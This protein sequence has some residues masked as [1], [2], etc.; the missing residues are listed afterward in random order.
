MRRKAS[1]Q[2][3]KDSMEADQAVSWSLELEAD[4]L[5]AM[6]C[7]AHCQSHGIPDVSCMIGIQLCIKTIESFEALDAF[8]EENPCVSHPPASMRMVQLRKTYTKFEALFDAIDEAFRVLWEDFFTVKF[9]RVAKLYSGLDFSAIGWDLLTGIAEDDL[10]LVSQ[11]QFE[12]GSSP[13]KSRKEP[14]PLLTEI[15]QEPSCRDVIVQNNI[16][17]IYHRMGMP[18]HARQCL[19]KSVSIMSQTELCVSQKQIILEN[20]LKLC[21]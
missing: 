12:N 18:A 20:Q 10:L 16:G 5:G 14:L 15:G 2:A 13:R 7:V 9:R 21:K 19:R 6:L 3:S 11:S 1:L 4:R 17:R 8:F